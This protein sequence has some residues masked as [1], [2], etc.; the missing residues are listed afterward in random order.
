[1][2]LLEKMRAKKEAIDAMPALPQQPRLIKRQSQCRPV[3]L[4]LANKQK[5]FSSLQMAAKWLTTELDQPCS[6]SGIG[7]AIRR[8]NPY[9]GY[10]F[11]YEEGRK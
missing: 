1:M 11:K 9:K 8:N 5:R 4:L 6:P 3:L 7:Q 2:T 10:K